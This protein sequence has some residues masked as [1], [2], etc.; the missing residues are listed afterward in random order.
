MSKSSISVP[1][2]RSPYNY[3]TKAASDESGLKCEDPSLTQQQFK[4]ETDINYIV[5]TYTR[6]GVLPH[7]IG[8]P[9]F[10]DFTGAQD[11]HSSVNQVIAAQQSFMALPA[12]LRSRFDNDPGQLLD[13][14]ADGDNRDEAIKLGLLDASKSDLS[15]VGTVSKQGKGPAGE[16]SV[17]G[18]PK[19]SS[20]LSDMLPKGFKIVPADDFGGDEGDE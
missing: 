18:K 8:T 20:R 5:D 9:Q 13:F 12:Q 17:S 2:V 19:A 15:P 1:F 3:D 6:T 4:E 10:G 7:T 14:L 11:Y 16:K